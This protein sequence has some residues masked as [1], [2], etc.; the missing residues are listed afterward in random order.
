MKKITGIRVFVAVGIVGKKGEWAG[1]KLNR[2][3][4]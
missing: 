2:P 3:L 4:G 1:A